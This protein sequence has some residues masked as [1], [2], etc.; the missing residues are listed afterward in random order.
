MGLLLGL[1]VFALVVVLVFYIIG[2]LG[3]PPPVDRAVRLVFGI[4]F[5][6]YLIGL[7]SGMFPVPALFYPHGY[8]RL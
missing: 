2:V 8:N 7:V 5:L 6:I 3:L 4:V 1:L